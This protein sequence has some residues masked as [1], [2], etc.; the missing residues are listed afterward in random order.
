[1]WACNLAKGL[2]GGKGRSVWGIW[3]RDVWRICHMWR[4][5]MSL[6][7]CGNLGE[8]HKD[9]RGGNIRGS[10]NEALAFWYDVNMGHESMKYLA[11][12]G[13]P[14]PYLLPNTLNPAYPLLAKLFNYI[15]L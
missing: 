15:Q 4:N 11:K 8:L 1:M 2:Y 6:A 10:S 9:M 5:P 13:C 12:G 7:R 14:P 3:V